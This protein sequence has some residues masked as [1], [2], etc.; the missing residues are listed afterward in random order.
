MLCTKL[1]LGLYTKLGLPL[2][3]HTK[4]SRPIRRWKYR[5]NYVF[6]PWHKQGIRLGGNLYHGILCGVSVV[7]GR[8]CQLGMVAVE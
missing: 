2:C 1:G 4:K 5:D 3:V 7:T 8:Y 6:I